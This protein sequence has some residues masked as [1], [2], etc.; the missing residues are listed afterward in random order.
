ML[1]LL[2][3]FHKDHVFMSINPPNGLEMS[4]LTHKAAVDE[5]REDIFPIWPSGVVRQHYDGRDW[6][7]R[8]AGRP[9]DLKGDQSILFV[10]SNTFICCCID[11]STDH[12][13]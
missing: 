3:P 12:R 1:F 6:H 13:E 11:L 5:M 9:W 2:T 8:F 10:S 7:V 4:N